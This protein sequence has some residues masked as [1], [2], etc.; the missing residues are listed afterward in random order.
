MG[1]KKNS[2]KKKLLYLLEAHG[3]V[4]DGHVHR[5]H[6]E[7]HARELALQ[8]GQHGADSLGGSRRGRDDVGRGLFVFFFE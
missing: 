1:G 2:R 6:A 3:Q 7:G 5:G 4:D 8:L